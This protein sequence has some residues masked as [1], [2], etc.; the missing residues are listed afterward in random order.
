MDAGFN[1]FHMEFEMNKQTAFLWSL[2]IYVSYI[3]DI[4]IYDIYRY[5]ACHLTKV[6]KLSQETFVKRWKY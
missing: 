6:G 1:W 5:S 2:Y 4:Y 3:Y